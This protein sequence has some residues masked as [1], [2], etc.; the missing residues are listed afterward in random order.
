MVISLFCTRYYQDKNPDLSKP[1]NKKLHEKDG[2]QLPAE[3]K[4]V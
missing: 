3:M 4:T 1:K 2:P